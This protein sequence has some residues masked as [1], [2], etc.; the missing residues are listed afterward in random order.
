MAVIDTITIGTDTFSVY[1]LTLTAAVSET[2]TF[3]NGRLGAER[4]A[5]DAAVTAGVDDEKRA[6][7]AAADW[8]DRAS[9]FS[10]DKTVATQARDWPRDSATNGCTGDAIA[11][12]TT[13]DDI[14]NAQAWLAGAILVD[15]AASASTGEGANIKSA[16]AGTAQVV[17]FRPTTGTAED[18][19]LPTVANDYAKCYTDAGTS[20]GIAGPTFTGT[21]Q[22]SSF[23]P[24]DDEFNEGLA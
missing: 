10:G 7:A 2:S 1:A 11:D 22:A 21:G 3:W 13:P 23:C 9:L 18:T 4:T 15:N 8:L 5:W 6:L 17:F 12:G 20:S 24:D 16:K 14:F 19:R